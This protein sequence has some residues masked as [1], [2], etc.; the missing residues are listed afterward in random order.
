MSDETER[1]L[2]AQ[3]TF[4][5]S[6]IDEFL[7]T[8]N[9]FDIDKFKKMFQAI[10]ETRQEYGKIDQS[11][12]YLRLKGT[13]SNEALEYIAIE[14]VS[15]ANAKFYVDSLREES[16]KRQVEK[17]VLTGKDLL[18]NSQSDAVNIASTMMSMLNKAINEHSEEKTSIKEISV[19]Y[20]EILEHRIRDRRND[21]IVVPRFG[22]MRLD[23]LCDQMKGGEVVV[24][25][26]RP[27]AGK[28][29]LALQLVR[30]SAISYKIP[31]AV[32]SLEMRKDEIMDRFVAQSGVCSVSALRGGYVSND[33]ID[34]VHDS[35]AEMY[36]T[37]VF[38]YDIDSDISRICARIRRDVAV[39]KVKMVVLDYIGLIKVDTHSRTPRWEQIGEISRQLK[40]LA[41]ELDIIL[42]EVVQLGR[43]AQNQEPSM[44]DLRDSGCLAG[45]TLIYRPD[46]RKAIKIKDMVGE[47]DFKTLSYL[48]NQIIED[49]GSAC[50]KT[51]DKVVRDLTLVNGQSIG[52]TD[53]HRFMTPDGWT[54]LASL[55]EGDLIAVPIACPDIE[56]G[57]SIAFVPIKSIKNRGVE[58]V[59]DIAVPISRNFIANNILV[60]NCLEQDSSRIILLHEKAKDE[61]IRNVSAIVAKNRHGATG[62]AELLFDGAHVKFA[63][64]T[65]NV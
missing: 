27:G 3:I 21:N 60:H 50:W 35:I 29:A 14:P 63:D 31:A 36:A 46:L 34:S 9:L 54:Y 11:A 30:H 32:F 6:I 1:T 16:Q 24:I 17:A 64:E 22:L 10:R 13:N 15:S 61:K 55:H 20:V 4:D 59:F 5:P 18:K 65:A 42:I 43:P 52:A 39:N 56:D 25:A 62:K 53:E 38:I 7:I 45:D 19:D 51:G 33:Q 48:N 8:E 26:G 23:E 12:V 47:S 44:A 58:E 57:G 49:V 40:L 2:I 41:L 28:S 37:P